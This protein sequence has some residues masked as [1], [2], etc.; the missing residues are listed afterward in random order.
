[1]DEGYAVPD[2]PQDGLGVGAA[3]LDPVQVEFQ[4]HDRRVG[5]PGE[6]IPEG[7]LAEGCELEVVVVVGEGH[8]SLAAHLSPPVEALGQPG[9][10]GFVATI[11]RRGYREDGVGALEDVQVGDDRFRVRLPGVEGDMGAGGAE[12]E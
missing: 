8:I 1:M 11:L 5:F 4:S 2:V 6:D 7:A 10:R 12:A 3:V 9:Y